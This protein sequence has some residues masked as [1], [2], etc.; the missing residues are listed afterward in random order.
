MARLPRFRSRPSATRF[1]VLLSNGNRI[2]EETLATDATGPLGGPLPEAELPVRAGRGRPARA[3]PGP[4]RTRGAARAPRDLGRAGRRARSMRHAHALLQRSMRWDEERFGLE[5]D[6][7]VLH[8]RRGDDFNMGAMENKGLNVFNEVRPRAPG[9][10]DRRRLRGHRGRHRPRVLPQLDRQPRDLP[11]LVPAH[12]EGRPDRLPRPASSRADDALRGGQAHRR[13]C[14][15]ARAPV[16]RGRGPDGASDPPESY[17][18]INNFYTATV[19]E[20][21]AEVIRMLRPLLGDD[22]FRAAWTSTS[23][24]TTARP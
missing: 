16:P 13:T 12:A 10:R 22:G 4:V 11:R 2:A 18:E 19:Y 14:A 9:D 5:Y 20:K 1:P 7:D 3:T 17:I 23:S 15:A 6:L 21:G 8:D 24:A